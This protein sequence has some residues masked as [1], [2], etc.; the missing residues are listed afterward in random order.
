MATSVVDDAGS[1]MQ[2][3]EAEIFGPELGPIMALHR[4]QDGYIS[5]AV[6]RDEGND[7]YF[8]PLVA[9]RR[10]ELAQY[11]PEFRDQL[12]KDSYVSINAGWRLLR[13]GPDGPAYG[14][15]MHRTDRLRYLCAAYAD[16]DYYRLR[17]T[18]GHA[19]G[20]VV[21]M[22]D[23]GE[24]PKASIIVKSGRGMWLIYLLHDLKDPS[25]VPGAFP[26]KKEM[27]YRLQRAI[28]ERLAA[29]ASD[30]CARDAARYVRVPGSLHTGSEQYAKWWIQ[31]EGPQAYKYSL[32][33]L[34]GLF[35]VAA[36]VRHKKEKDAAIDPETRALK[37]R[38]HAALNA[39]RLRDFN[40]VRS[41][42]GGF[43]KGCR[44]NAAMV[45][46]WLLHRAG[47]SRHE[48]LSQVNLMGAECHPPLTPS[49]C[50]DAIKTGFGRTMRRMLDQS[51]VDRLGMT[52]GELSETEFRV[53]AVGPPVP[54][55]S[56][57]REKGIMARREKI[58]VIIGE[59]GGEVPPVREMGRRLIEAGFLGN[60]QTVQKDYIALGIQ[61]S[62]TRAAREAERAKQLVFPGA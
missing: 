33:Q 21:D 28:G 45:Y 25:R 58:T 62:R 60:H 48:A 54:M 61:S 11:F 42:R 13:N 6:A 16:L 23:A 43:S 50:R 4:H 47:V 57:I 5:F 55:P 19:L 31:G 7:K 29:L 14:H 38:G 3:A 56:E 20:K 51:I 32:P 10:D 8:K 52:A 9:I 15:P 18:F 41:M 2:P 40:L 39:R 22:Q 36:P 49:E 35:G 37:L 12:L 34:C 24:L 46:A 1:R 53:K 27:Y 30:P 17:M 44:N 26:E 59:M